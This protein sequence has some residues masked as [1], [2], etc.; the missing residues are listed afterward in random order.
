M[1]IFEAH[2]DTMREFLQHVTETYGGAEG[3][4][5]AKGMAPQTV[6]RLRADLLQD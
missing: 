6:A 5:L 4:V 2:P 3:Y 1:W